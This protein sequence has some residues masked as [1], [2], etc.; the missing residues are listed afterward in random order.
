MV[1]YQQ[2]Y[3]VDPFSSGSWIISSA[4]G[5]KPNSDLPKDS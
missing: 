5:D 4:V 1:K 3:L 2:S